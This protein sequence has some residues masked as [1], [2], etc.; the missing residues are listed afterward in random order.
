LHYFHKVSPLFDLY[1]GLLT[2]AR[3]SALASAFGGVRFRENSLCTLANIGIVFKLLA[4][5]LLSIS[6]IGSIR[7]W[8][9]IFFGELGL[10]PP[11]LFLFILRVWLIL[12]E[13][14]G[15]I[16]MAAAAASAFFIPNS[17]ETDRWLTPEERGK[18]AN[19]RS[20]DV[21]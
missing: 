10:F 3:F 19:E 1:G 5:G 6:H 15:L 8:R 13:V 7:G 14:E 17:P 20:Q 9:T 11:F 12:T 16:T 4:S 2:E 18:S 21:N